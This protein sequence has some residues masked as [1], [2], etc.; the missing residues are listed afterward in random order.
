MKSVSPRIAAVAIPAAPLLTGA[1]ILSGATGPEERV[2][3][4]PYIGEAVRTTAG[5]GEMKAKGPGMIK[6]RE[7]A[8]PG[9]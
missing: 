7:E 5:P 8:V 6:G 9:E 4:P 2:R 3:I 1:S